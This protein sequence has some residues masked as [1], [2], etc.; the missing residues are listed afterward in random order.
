MLRAALLLFF[1]PAFS[2]T[3]VYGQINREQDVSKMFFE[4]QDKCRGLLRAQN[5]KEAEPVCKAAARLAEQLP[6]DRALE[7]MGAYQLLGHVFLRQQRYQEALNNYS[8]AYEF[9]RSQ[10]TEK[11]AELG[12]LYGYMAIAHHGLNELDKAREFYRK[13]EKSLQLAY[14]AMACD[15]CDEEVEKIRQEYIKR[16]KDLLEYH[17]V[18]AE[19]AGAAAEVEE[20]KKLQRSLP[21]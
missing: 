15:N 13:A 5:W 2:L 8:R 18:A 7:K 20:I 9:A 19:Q 1:L 14:A 3:P 10:L 6:G 4:Q 21:K 11:N 17:L 16:L 12:E